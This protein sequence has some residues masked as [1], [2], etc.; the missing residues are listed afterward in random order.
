LSGQTVSFFVKKELFPR[1]A[2]QP[3][4]DRSLL[5]FGEVEAGDFSSQGTRFFLYQGLRFGPASQWRPRDSGF[6]WLVIGWPASTLS[7]REGDQPATQSM[8]TT[9]ARSPLPR[10]HF[11]EAR[12]PRTPLP[13]LEKDNRARLFAGTL[14]R[15]G[16]GKMPNEK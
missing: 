12:G 6:K 16:G 14:A 2:G 5:L 9:T 10:V 8:K 13:R 15:I 1:N 7:K 3:T 4:S 11:F